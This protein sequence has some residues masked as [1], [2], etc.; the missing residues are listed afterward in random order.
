MSKPHVVRLANLH[1][2]MERN[3]LVEWL[4]QEGDPVTKGEPLYL[5]E[6]RKGLFEVCCE[7]EGTIER[8]LVPEGSP[9]AADQEIALLRPV[10]DQET[11][12]A[13]GAAT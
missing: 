10:L 9:V 8:W 6:T 3:V 1:P 4:K 7:L 5:V 13:G 2:H 11:G 12:E